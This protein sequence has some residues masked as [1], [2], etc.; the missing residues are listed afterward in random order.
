MRAET[1][2]ADSLGRG[3]SPAL[4]LGAQAPGSLSTHPL[5]LGSRRAWNSSWSR[6]ALGRCKK[7]EV[8]VLGLR[9]PWE[10]RPVPG[11]EQGPEAQFSGLARPGSF[12]AVIQLGRVP[13][14]VCGPQERAPFPASEPDLRKETLL[15]HN[16][17][18]Q[19]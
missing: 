12:R 4:L 11:D 17:A 2:G 3:G 8:R 14:W 15:L 7:A 5:A 19:G 1:A 6:S 16:Q 18:C 10:H 13:V 9:E